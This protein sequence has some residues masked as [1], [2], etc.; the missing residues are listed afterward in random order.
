MKPDNWNE[1]GNLDKLKLAE[2]MVNSPRGAYII[3]QALH[4]AIKALN[5]IPD[6][7][8]EV[9]NIQDMEMMRE[10]FFDFP[11]FEPDLDAMNKAIN[12]GKVRSDDQ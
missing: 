8:K 12:N 11:V 6:P 10:T 9:S 2:K 4:Y 3:S 7:F 1:M 5:E